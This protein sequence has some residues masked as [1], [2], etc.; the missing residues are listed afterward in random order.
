VPLLD[1]VVPSKRLIADKTY[2][3]DRLRTWLKTRRIK[4]VIPST[5]TRTI[6][7]PL[8]YADY[9]RRNVIERLFCHLKNW[10]RVATCYDRLARNYLA[11][12][13]LIAVVAEWT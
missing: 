12:V 7:Y 8:D 6:P 5:A 10:R 4:A 2:N 11:G 3:V 1:A 13:A 9:R